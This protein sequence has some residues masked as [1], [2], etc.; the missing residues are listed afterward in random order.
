MGVKWQY[1]YEVLHHSQDKTEFPK[2][3]IAQIGILTSCAFCICMHATAHNE[4]PRQVSPLKSVNMAV[5]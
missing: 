5:T 3:E 1:V 4:H 2:G